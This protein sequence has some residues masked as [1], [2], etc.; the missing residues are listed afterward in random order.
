LYEDART[1]TDA[2]TFAQHVVVSVVEQAKAAE[3]LVEREGP[4][5]ILRAAGDELAL[6][7]VSIAKKGG[8]G[9][10]L[11]LFKANLA[12]EITRTL[13]GM[14]IAKPAAEIIGALDD[15]IEAIRSEGFDPMLVIDDSD[16][17]L[18]LPKMESRD[19]LVNGFFRETVPMLAK[20]GVGFVMAIH[21]TYESQ[22]G[23]VE[24][25]KEGELNTEIRVPPLFGASHVKAILDRRIAK[26]APEASA[27]DVFEDGVV[28]L[29]YA[30]Y[31]GLAG[32]NTRNMLQQVHSGLVEAHARGDDLVHVDLVQSLIA[33]DS[34]N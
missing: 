26:H 10:P 15:A 19:E 17:W 16:R 28:E 9:I 22:P 5:K 6:A 25:R 32:L 7:S 1:L 27:E 13:E 4:E 30:Y 24:A 8:I 2:K 14:T 11:W 23:Y 3:L 34:P 21:T 31:E 18:S 29:Y 12:A 20:R 33:G